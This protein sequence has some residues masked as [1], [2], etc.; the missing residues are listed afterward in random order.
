[1]IEKL[2]E[3]GEIVEMRIRE[4]KSRRWHGECGGCDALW[5]FTTLGGM[6]LVQAGVAPLNFDED[7][8]RGQRVFVGE[9]YDDPADN[10]PRRN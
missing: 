1:M 8:M 4:K 6:N 7:R 9:R 10:P 5:S 3:C 2:C